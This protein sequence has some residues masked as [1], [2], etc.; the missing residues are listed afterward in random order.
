MLIQ[1]CINPLTYCI[2]SH[3]SQRP[4]IYL[5]EDQAQDFQKNRSF[6]ALGYQVLLISTSRVDQPDLIYQMKCLL[7]D[8]DLL[9]I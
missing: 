7:K 6:Q 3:F 1:A 4:R 8:D 2:V 5:L 9:E